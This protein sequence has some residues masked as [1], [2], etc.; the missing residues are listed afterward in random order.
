MN[1]EVHRPV[2][3]DR[4]G[5]QGSAFEIDAGPDELSAIAARLRVIAL[6]SLHCAF[7]LRRIGATTIEAQGVLH[8]RVT[9]TCVVSLDTSK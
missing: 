6:A 9:E 3:L 2:A 8:A 1:P 7:K 4:I 5:P